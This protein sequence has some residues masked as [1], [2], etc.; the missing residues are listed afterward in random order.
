M[1]FLVSC[2]LYLGIA[3]SAPFTGGHLNPSVT[4]GVTAAGLSPVKDMIIYIVSQVIGA[5]F[6]VFICKVEY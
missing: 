3:V 2:F 6:G 4:I 1:T 5:I